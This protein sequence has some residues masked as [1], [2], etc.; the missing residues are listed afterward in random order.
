MGVYTDIM[1]DKARK[2]QKSRKELIKEVEKLT[3]QLQE[4]ENIKTTATDKKEELKGFLK[5]YFYQYFTDNVD[6]LTYNTS[7]EGVYYQLLILSKKLE[8]I[9]QIA[10]ADNS[11]LVYLDNIYK[12]TLNKIYKDL[13]DEEKAKEML[14]PKRKLESWEDWE[15]IRKDLDVATNTPLIQEIYYSNSKKQVNTKKGFFEI[16]VNL[17][18]GG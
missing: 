15:E 16:L 10:Q 8:I 1:Q 18:L 4:K 11:A 13:K 12:T 14:K 9:K 2:E 7:F 3:K 5:Q 17:I 6:G